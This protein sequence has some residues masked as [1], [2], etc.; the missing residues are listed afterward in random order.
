MDVRDFLESLPNR[1]KSEALVGVDTVFHFDISDEGQGIRKTVSVA[2][3]T[4]N[5]Q[6]GL[7]GEPKCIVTASSE[8]LAAVLSALL[9]TW[10]HFLPGGKSAMRCSP[11][12]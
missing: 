5:V 4:I 2:D 8:D 11:W 9:Q 1:V 10:R 12:R 6:E 7:V 3:A